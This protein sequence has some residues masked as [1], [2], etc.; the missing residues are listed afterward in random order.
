MEVGKV[1]R[2][3]FFCEVENNASVIKWD[4]EWF[5]CPRMRENRK[6]PWRKVKKHASWNQADKSWKIKWSKAKKSCRRHGMNKES[7]RA[8]MNVLV[9]I[10][11]VLIVFIY[12]VVRLGLGKSPGKYVNRCLINPSSHGPFFPRHLT[13]SGR[14]EPGSSGHMWPGPW[15][16]VPL[17]PSP[18]HSCRRALNTVSID[19]I[20]F[21]IVYVA[22]KVGN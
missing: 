15:D 4:K 20:S 17:L 12:S 5:K 10:K 2:F 21:N 7:C 6:T 9:F 19:T 11:F 13:P 16:G 18:H 8:P 22:Y 1:S 14:I 3:K